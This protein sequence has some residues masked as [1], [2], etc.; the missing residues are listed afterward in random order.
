MII[1]A[2]LSIVIMHNAIDR[3]LILFPEIE[4]KIKDSEE[5]FP[6]KEGPQLP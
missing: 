1:F 4:G 3:K 6:V 5:V 2:F